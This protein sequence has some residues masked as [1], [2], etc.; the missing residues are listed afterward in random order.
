MHKLDSQSLMDN[1]V[2]T[3]GYAPSTLRKHKMYYTEK[4]K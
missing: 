3:K 1:L 2:E 4:G